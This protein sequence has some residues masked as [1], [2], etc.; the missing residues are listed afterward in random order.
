MIMVDSAFLLMGA[1]LL[2]RA[3]HKLAEEQQA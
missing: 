1:E 3:M 2:K